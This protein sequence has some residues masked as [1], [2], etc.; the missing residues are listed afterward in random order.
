MSSHNTSDSNIS[1]KLDLNSSGRSGGILKTYA[2]QFHSE[3]LN[4]PN[5][6]F[7]IKLKAFF[8]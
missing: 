6:K 2:P 5:V 7:K 3:L 4:D 1:L 8:V